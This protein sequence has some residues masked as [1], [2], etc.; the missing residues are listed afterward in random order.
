MAGELYMVKSCAMSFARTSSDDP[1]QTHQGISELGHEPAFH[2][3]SFRE[4]WL[5]FNKMSLHD[6]R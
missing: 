5:G 1:E 4:R 6:D 2:N 3:L